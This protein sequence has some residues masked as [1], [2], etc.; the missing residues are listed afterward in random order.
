LVGS[1]FYWRNRVSA[2]KWTIEHNR[3][4]EVDFIRQL[5]QQVQ[6]NTPPDFQPKLPG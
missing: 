5:K 2:K 3:K 6:D 1:R 4:L